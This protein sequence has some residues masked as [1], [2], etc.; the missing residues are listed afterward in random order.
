MLYVVYSIGLVYL[1]I[2]G[3][4]GLYALEFLHI[5]HANGMYMINDMTLVCWACPAY[6]SFFVFIIQLLITL[7]FIYLFSLYLSIYLLYLFIYI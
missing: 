5:Q 1:I 3:R 2:C 4:T 6:A 7:L